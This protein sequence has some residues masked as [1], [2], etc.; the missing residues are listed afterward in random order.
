MFKLISKFGIIEPKV[1]FHILLWLP[2]SS[3]PRFPLFMVSCNR[4]AQPSFDLVEIKVGSRSQTA[5][6]SNEEH[7]TQRQ[8]CCLPR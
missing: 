7:K 1:L 3:K 4:L 2:G 5:L 8:S 6:S